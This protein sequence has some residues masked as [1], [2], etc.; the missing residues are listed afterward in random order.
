[1]TNGTVPLYN[2]TVI[3]ATDDKYFNKGFTDETGHFEILTEFPS[4]KT[5]LVYCFTYKDT[6]V[7]GIDGLPLPSLTVVDTRGNDVVWGYVT[8]NITMVII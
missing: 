6:Y 8:F 3:A 2:V 5:M 1:V 7:N 4:N